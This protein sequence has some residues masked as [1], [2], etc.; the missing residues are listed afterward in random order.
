MSALKPHFRNPDTSVLWHRPVECAE[1]SGNALR[2]FVAFVACWTDWAPICYPP[3]SR[4][5]LSA[6]LSRLEPFLP[7]VL[8]SSPSVARKHDPLTVQ[9]LALPSPITSG[10]LTTEDA[11]AF[12][13]AAAADVDLPLG[14]ADD[15]SRT[16]LLPDRTA[17]TTGMRNTGNDAD[18]ASALLQHKTALQKELADSCGGTRSTSLV[19]WGRTRGG[20]APRRRW[21]VRT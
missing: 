11:E 7:A 5:F 9:R 3:T 16:F 10:L 6:E 4:S 19:R 20:C 8:H 1:S 17:S 18:S 14:S 2:A 15:E 21:W 13:A 12:A